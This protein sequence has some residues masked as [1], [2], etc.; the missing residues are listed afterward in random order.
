MKYGDL[1]QQYGKS[2]EAKNPHEVALTKVKGHATWQMISN[3]VG[4]A[5]DRFGWSLGD[6]FHGLKFKTYKTSTQGP[7]T[8]TCQWFLVRLVVPACLW[9]ENYKF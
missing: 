5:V 3:G 6:P 2:A 1:W 4:R 7:L 8:R 9:F